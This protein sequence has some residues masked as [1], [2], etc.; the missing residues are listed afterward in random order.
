MV[1]WGMIAAITGVGVAI[2]MRW[3]IEGVALAWLIVAPI[4]LVGV[5]VLASGV[6]S[7]RIV[8]L[9][10]SIYR[11][12]LATGMMAGA[13]MLARFGL[14]AAVPSVGGLAVEVLVGAGVFGLAMLAF[15][16][17]AVAEIFQI[18]G[19]PLPSWLRASRQ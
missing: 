19:L 4:T 8:D 17:G 16:R 1:A 14:G 11:P 2:G 13:V 5:V 15:D 7:F 9:V 3:G 10:E 12:V 6:L 18:A